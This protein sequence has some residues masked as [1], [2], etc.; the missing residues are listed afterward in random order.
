MEDMVPRRN[1]LAT[2]AVLG[3]LMGSL[4]LAPSAGAAANPYRATTICGPGY[5]VLVERPIT[6]GPKVHGRLVFL[7][8]DR[9]SKFCAVSLKTSLVGTPSWTDVSIAR[10]NASKYE[11]DGDFFSYYAGPVYLRGTRTSTCML[12]SG[13]MQIPRKRTTLSAGSFRNPWGPC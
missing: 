11:S 12:Y 2:T 10:P 6:F 8:N 13:S 1:V 4:A 3:A 7:R 5:K 9:A